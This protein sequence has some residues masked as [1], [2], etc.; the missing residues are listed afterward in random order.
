MSI[1][2]PKEF[3]YVLFTASLIGFQVVVTGGRFPGSARKVFDAD[4]FKKAKE[5]G[6]LEEHKKATGEEKISGGCYPD[7]G[8]GR[9]AALLPYASW[10]K[11]N[12]AQRVHLNYVEGVATALVQL[13]V[14]GAFYPRAATI[15][16]LGYIVGRE[17]YA[18]GYA[19][20]GPSARMAGALIFDVALIAL[21]GM[22]AYGSFTAAGGAS[23]FASF[24]LGK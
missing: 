22:A 3:S 14:A 12:N 24:L 23:A 20:R 5:T 8:N 15:A 7:T 18:S 19:S 6:L 10:L 13:L 17:V 11:F 21:F 2:I 16:G 4:F 1:S 9:Y